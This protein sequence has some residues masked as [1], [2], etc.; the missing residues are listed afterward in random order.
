MS[1]IPLEINALPLKRLV[2]H[3]TIL[4][5]KMIY[6]STG[7]PHSI[8]RVSL[9]RKL[10]RVIHHYNKSLYKWNRSVYTSSIR[11]WNKTIPVE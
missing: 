8:S 5:L 6:Y 7:I 3:W 4:V 2:F 9:I 10:I 1:G 11:V